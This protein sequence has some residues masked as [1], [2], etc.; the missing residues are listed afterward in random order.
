M[1]TFS[2]T[3]A[4]KD[5][6][7]YIEHYKEIGTLIESVPVE[8]DY[9]HCWRCKNPVI[10]KTTK[11]WF[12]KIEDLKE[13]MIKENEKI[14]WVPEA[15]FN[16]FDS[17]LKNLRDNSITKQ[18]YW[19]TP[20]PIW[21]CEC[22]K[23][24]VIGS[25]EELEEKAGSIPENLHKPWI[26]EVTM[27]CECGKTMKRIPDIIDVWVDAG[28]A[29]W[30]C[31]DYPRSE[32][33][34][35]EMFPAEF[36]LEGKDQIRGW[37][38]LLMVAS[39]ISLEKISFK[40][41]Y[42]H[43]FIQDSQGRKMSKSLGNY[44]LPEEVLSQYGADTVRNYFIGGANPGVDLNY[45]FDDVK[46][47]YKNLS[48][49][50]NLHKFILNYIKQHPYDKA[51]KLGLEEKYIL[52]K[53][54]STIKL[55]TE[56][57]NNYLLNETPDLIEELF[58]ELSRTYI[59]LIRDKANLGSEEEKQTISYTLHTVLMETLKMLAPIMPFATE[60]MYLNLKEVTN[61]EPNSIH[62]F[63]WPEPN[64]NLINT[65]LEEQIEIMKTINQQILNSREKIQRGVRW[66]VKEVVVI[67]KK[68]EVKA[69]IENLKELIKTQ[70]N[71][72][73]I[74]LKESMEGTVEKAK[75]DYK[76]IKDLGD[77]AAL[78]IAKFS[79]S[80]PDLVL[81]KIEEH[82]AF[83]VEVNKKNYEITKQHLIIEKEA[84]ENFELNESRFADVYLNKE[85]SEELEAE[86]F[87]RELVRRMQMLRKN[88]KLTKEDKVNIT[89]ITSENLES[90]LKPYFETIKEKVGA[91]HL[92]ISSDKSPEE[93]QFS[94]DEKI[95]AEI[96]QIGMDK[97]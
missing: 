41:C 16:A 15:A 84:P 24:E 72:K 80:S 87:S 36:I 62:L 68:E 39:M 50:W 12:F 96:I 51:L 63:D 70:T 79:Q 91:S 57:F 38:N 6:K 53:L 81:E 52:S 31:L 25:A 17:W 90:S 97:L 71:V 94:S 78:I 4:K 65:E 27:P 40:N 88:S 83:I 32:Q 49:L 5:D 64:Y 21:K 45:N 77:D 95:K 58:L 1:G 37:F 66:P 55:V 61:S 46:V 22:G 23:Y 76:K 74:T 14:K 42:M 35:N 26:D 11:Q 30:N 60:K 44:I 20:I 47:K 54:N 82:G 29:S 8:H 67:T 69:A 75:L 86:G 13:K 9:A 56:K 59:Q 19:G 7:K 43:G 18:R 34:F 85:T 93:Y 33:K 48:I 73:E 28:S 89:L 2:N 3:I 10:Y 92:E